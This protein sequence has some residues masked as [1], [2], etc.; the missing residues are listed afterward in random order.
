[1]QGRPRRQWICATVAEARREESFLDICQW[2]FVRTSWCRGGWRRCVA[3]ACWEACARGRAALL[4]PTRRRRRRRLAAAAACLRRC[5]ILSRCLGVYSEGLSAAAGALGVWVDEHKLRPARRRVG[6]RWGASRLL[7]RCKWARGN[8]TL[9]LPRHSSP[10]LCMHN[11]ML[12]RRRQAP[13]PQPRALRGTAVHRRF[14]MQQ[15]PVAAS[16][17][18]KGG[19]MGGGTV[20]GTVGGTGG[21]TGGGSTRAAS[22]H[23]AALHKAHAS[24]QHMRDRRQ[25]RGRS[26]M[27]GRAGAPGAAVHISH[28]KP[29]A[30]G[31]AKR[32]GQD[33]LRRPRAHLRRSST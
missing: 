8:G 32:A 19:G 7:A 10:A 2:G 17:K 22:S 23:E 3:H 21:G 1:M 24:A 31:A 30:Q 11:Q 13:T 25:Q 14:G 6:V 15:Q 33:A 12:Q 9:Q 20:G 28:R 27:P 4:L 16:R 18:P 5:C 26:R 29:T